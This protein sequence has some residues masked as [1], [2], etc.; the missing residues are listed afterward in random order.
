MRNG[1]IRQASIDDPNLT[2]PMRY[3]WQDDARCAE[4]GVEIFF[5]GKG[6]STL[7][8]KNMCEGCDVVL[9]CLKYQ[10][11]YEAENDG[12]YGIFGGLSERERR[13]L[14]KLM[15]EKPFL[16]LEAARNELVNGR[17]QKGLRKDSRPV[18][19]AAA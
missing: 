9:Q 1:S 15:K 8:A 6:G 7:D 4:V 18:V 11:D 17:R 16:D 3:I 5:P 13:K 12:Y 14:V 2:P 10:M 19:K